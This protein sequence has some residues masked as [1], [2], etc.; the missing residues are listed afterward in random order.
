MAAANYRSRPD[1]AKW[2]QNQ[3]SGVRTRQNQTL[4][5][6]LRFLNCVERT[7][8]N[9][10]FRFVSQLF[11]VAPDIAGILPV[12]IELGFV[13]LSICHRRHTLAAKTMFQFHQLWDANVVQIKCVWPLTFYEITNDVVIVR[14]TQPS[15]SQ[16]AG[17]IPD[18]S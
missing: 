3:I 12:L 15:L 1:T 7:S 6:S 16:T 4:N 5:Q 11:Y 8:I 17:L 14:V 2:I 18:D 9:K 10:L 13:K